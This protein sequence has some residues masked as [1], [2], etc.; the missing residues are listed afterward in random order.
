[1]HVHELIFDVKTFEKQ[2]DS[3][4]QI[5]LLIDDNVTIGRFLMQFSNLVGVHE[6][7]TG[8][9]LKQYLLD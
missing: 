9:W 1:M 4:K 2:G 6:N 7:K 8:K 3:Y 5:F